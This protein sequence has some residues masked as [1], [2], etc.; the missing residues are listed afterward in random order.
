MAVA[1][2]VREIKRHT[3]GW[4]VLSLVGAVVI[5]LP[6]L[7]ILASLFGPPNENWPHIQA[8][9]LKDYLLESLWLVLLTGGL[10][11]LLGVS[12]AWLIAA[13]DFPMK[14]FFRWALM[15][16]LAV[17]PYVA[18]YTYS[19]MFSYTGVVQNTLRS[20]GLTPDAKTFGVMSLRGAVFVFTLFLFPY[21]YMVTRSFL[22][23]QSGSYIENAILLGRSPLAIFTR[24][25]LP[26]SRPAIV[27]GVTL[28]VFE[29]LGDYGVTSY[30]GVH[31]I[32]T[33]IFRTWFG[34][35]D[36]DSAVR[37][38]AWLMVGVVGLFILERLL[39]Q[40]RRFSA[41]TSKT[42]PLVPRRL[43][44]LEAVGAWTFCGLV[45][46]WSF[47][48]PIVQLGVW[49]TWTYKDVLTSGFFELTA[50]TASVALLATAL[51]MLFA[52]VVANVA[53]TQNNALSHTLSRLVTAGYSIPGAIVAIGV[54]AL[55][56]DLDHRLA[57]LY[58]WM[59]LGQKPLVLS[60]SVVMLVVAY[61]VRFMAT[62]YQAVDAG[63]EKVGTRFMEVSRMLGHGITGTFFKV[64]LPLIRGA[65]LSGAILTFVEI[66]KELPLAML[67]RPFN[68][69]TL[70]TKTYQYASNEQ[71]YEAA[72]PSLFIIGVS[73]LSV[74]VLHQVGKG[75]ES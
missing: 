66:V 7:P 2:V 37:L 71:I 48:I 40:G 63:F 60:L 24:I 19:T 29:V 9:L 33:A 16:P 51:V 57:P 28:V 41:S 70:A 34:M 44:G 42:R 17:P 5:L 36:V 75:S 59:G 14:R 61:I 62:G 26:I 20:F 11:A 22:E 49:S 53:R 55:F 52:V 54:L 46:A 68:F 23:R 21:V 43:H 31:T 35:Y 3:N 74:W 39:R 69:E 18:A 27:G 72:V 12:L 25:V 15:L 58:G 73:M 67:L 32:T 1:K 65:L 50:R 4:L 30:F 10:T 47:L 6:L 45:F 8:Y 56:I 13:Y 38:A 64:D